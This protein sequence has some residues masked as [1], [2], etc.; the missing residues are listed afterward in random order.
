VKILQFSYNQDYKHFLFPGSRRKFREKIILCEGLLCVAHT[1]HKKIERGSVEHGKNVII[2]WTTSG[3]K[4][5]W[6]LLWKIIIRIHIANN[7]MTYSQFSY[8]N[9]KERRN[10]W[11]NEWRKKEWRNLREKGRNTWTE[12]L[13]ENNKC[14]WL[15][16]RKTSEIFFSLRWIYFIFIFFGVHKHVLYWMELRVE[17]K[18]AALLSHFIRWSDLEQCGKY[19]GKLDCFLFSFHC[20][21]LSASHDRK[22]ASWF[23]FWINFNCSTYK[24]TCILCEIRSAHPRILE[25][26]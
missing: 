5:H 15:W 22:M 4:K 2:V 9:A 6:K 14:R 12:N 8:R 19:G 20:C 21:L 17:H 24:C 23:G 11:M 16:M 25:Y 7:I 10:E 13:H 18:H 1:T 3:C 26:L